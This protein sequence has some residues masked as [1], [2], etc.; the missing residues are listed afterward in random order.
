M[1]NNKK[2]FI[3]F[4]YLSVTVAL[5]V[6]MF[7]VLVYPQHDGEGVKK[8]INLCLYT[9]MPSM[10]PF[11]FLSSFIIS[12]SLAEKSELVFAFVTRKI[13]NLPG[14][15][16][17]IIILSMIGG[18]PVG[19]KAVEDAFDN[20][21]IT[22]TEGQRLLTFCINPGP[23]F[24]ITSV[25]FY[26]MNSKLVG[27]IIY[28][29]LVLSSLTI[30]F[31]TKFI[32]HSDGSFIYNKKEKATQITNFSVSLVSSVSTAIRSI[33]NVSSWVILFSCIIE[34]IGV[35]PL[36]EGTNLFISCITEMTT[37]VKVA[38]GKVP[39]P[40]IAGIIGFTGICGHMQIMPTVIKLKMP[41]R[42]FL[43]ARVINA[44][45]ATV[46][47]M[48]LLDVFFVSV[49]TVTIGYLPETLASDFSFPVCIGVL[50]MSVLLLLG[51]NFYVKNGSI[52]RWKKT[53]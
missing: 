31:L 26:F 9:L 32:F 47:S 42:Y 13:L 45:L 27:V 28:I 39:V 2:I 37:G 34:L 23:A 44:A 38:S 46:I 49:E 18:L 35:F 5:S 41:L 20:G 22:Q 43:A 4:S 15:C 36:S 11:M 21:C 24:V 14:I 52:L 12:S 50:I 33:I 40:I 29:S 8:G 17:V 51:D 1:K 3:I 10:Y 7:L 6:F 48:L 30:G 16:G 53:L 19:A 25:G